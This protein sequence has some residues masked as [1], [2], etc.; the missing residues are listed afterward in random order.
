MNS[1]IR[2]LPL[3]ETIK[4]QILDLTL[5]PQ[6]HVLKPSH[7]HPAP[8]ST[9]P[10]PTMT[11]LDFPG[12]PPASFTHNPFP[13]SRSIRQLVTSGGFTGPTSAWVCRTCLK[14]CA[15]TDESWSS[16]RGSDGLT[17]NGEAAYL[18]TLVVSHISCCTAIVVHLYGGN[19]IW[20]VAP[21][22]KCI[23]SNNCHVYDHGLSI[24]S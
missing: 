23:L 14:P 16:W 11:L 7:P 17:V 19:G 22:N 1:T 24:W 15:P 20:H 4:G 18:H 5:L 10:G 3:R 21:T 8:L 12:P 9:P 13:P 2:G 6:C